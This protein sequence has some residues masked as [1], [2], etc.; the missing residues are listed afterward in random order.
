MRKIV[1]VRLENDTTI[2]IIA[3]VKK[4]EEARNLAAKHFARLIGG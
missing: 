4:P 1:A 2:N 3:N